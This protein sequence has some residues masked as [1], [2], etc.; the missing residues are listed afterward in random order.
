MRNILSWVC[1]IA[2]FML[3]ITLSFYLSKY[4]EISEELLGAFALIISGMI[5]YRLGLLIQQKE[6]S[7]E[8]RIVFNC[9]ILG[10]VLM[11]I[12]TLL[13]DKAFQ[14]VY[15]R[16]GQYLAFILEAAAFAG[17]LWV[18]KQVYD[19]KKAEYEKKLKQSFKEYNK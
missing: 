11:T 15:S 3:L 6:L 5:S 19:K 9:W 14:D 1:S 12:L 13:I 10:L 16:K 7:G 8:N 18:T 17:T 4:M 2:L